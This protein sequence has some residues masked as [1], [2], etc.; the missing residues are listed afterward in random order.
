MSGEG[1]QQCHCHSSERNFCLGY[2]IPDNDKNSFKGKLKWLYGIYVNAA[3]VHFRVFFFFFPET[4]QF[5]SEKC[6][7]MKGKRITRDHRFH[8]NHLEMW[9]APVSLSLILPRLQFSA[10]QWR[11]LGR[12][13]DQ[14]G[15]WMCQSRVPRSHSSQFAIVFAKL[16]I[17]VSCSSCQIILSLEEQTKSVPCNNFQV[18]SSWCVWLHCRDKLPPRTNSAYLANLISYSYLQ[19]FVPWI[20]Y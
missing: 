4:I 20:A 16:C 9:K 5:N 13:L 11:N 19:A 3:Q 2:Y 7:S 8:F 10:K 1:L 18:P 12:L 6:Q 15:C 14:I 17:S